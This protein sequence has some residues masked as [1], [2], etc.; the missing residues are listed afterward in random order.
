MSWISWILTSNDTAPLSAPLRSR[1]KIIDLP[2]LTPGQ[3]I[4]FLAS[5]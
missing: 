1:V 5:K 2:A 4:G 3:L